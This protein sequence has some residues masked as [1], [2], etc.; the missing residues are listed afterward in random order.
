MQAKL[1][2]MSTPDYLL[3]AELFSVMNIP[4][5]MCNGMLKPEVIVRNRGLKTLF[6]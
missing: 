4:E 5:K 2:T 1:V 3:D 6:R